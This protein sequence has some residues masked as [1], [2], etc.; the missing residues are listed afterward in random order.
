MYTS[1]VPEIDADFPL[2]LVNHPSRYVYTEPWYY[3]VSHDMAFVQLFRA[4]DHIWLAQSPSGGGGVNPAW[5]FQWFIPGPEIGKAYGFVMRAL[6]L[7]FKD[8]PSL[9]KTVSPHLEVLNP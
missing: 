1:F 4:R 2:T 8:R 9:E 7:P 3:G 6:Y 5:D